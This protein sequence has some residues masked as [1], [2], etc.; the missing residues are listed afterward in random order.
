MREGKKKKLKVQR[1][2]CHKLMMKYLYV[3]RRR[4]FRTRNKRKMMVIP[5]IIDS[6]VPIGKDDSCNV[7]K[8]RFGK[9]YVPKYEIPY[10]ADIIEN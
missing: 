3:K 2:K 9:A 6:S 5:N 8:E 10:H 4:K 1:R 7:E